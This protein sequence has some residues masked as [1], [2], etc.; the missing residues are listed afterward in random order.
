MT[1]ASFPDWEAAADFMRALRPTVTEEA[2]LQRLQSMLSPLQALTV[3]QGRA[4]DIVN[5]K[6][7]KTG[8]LSTAIRVA[9]IAALHR[10]PCMMGCMIESSISAA[11]AAHLAVARSDVIRLIDLDGPSLGAFDPVVGGTHFDDAVVRLPDSPGLGINAIDG[12]ELLTD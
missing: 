4:A 11:A 12:L 7:M 6:L 1:P 9:D 5:I 2:R 10:V 3:I 8:G